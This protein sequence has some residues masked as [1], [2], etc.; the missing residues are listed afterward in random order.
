MKSNYEKST[1]LNLPNEKLFYTIGEVAE[2]LQVPSTTIRYWEKEFDMLHFA[3][4]SKGDR[5]FTKEDIELLQMIYQLTKVEGYKID[6]AKEIMR[7][8]TKELKEKI[9][10]IESLKRI[11][12][13][14]IFLKEELKT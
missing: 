9:R 10:T 14:L 4:N 3:K 8:K 11:K 13:F 6:A 5:R 2:I 7:T 1:T 12:E